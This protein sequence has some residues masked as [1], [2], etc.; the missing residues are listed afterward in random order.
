[1]EVSVALHPI[2]QLVVNNSIMPLHLYFIAAC[3]FASLFFLKNRGWVNKVTPLFLIVLF[4][5]EYY[6]YILKIKHR[7]NNYQYN[8][9]FPIEFSFY[10]LLLLSTFVKIKTKQKL[11]FLVYLYW[12][13]TIVNYCFFQN[14]SQ[15]SGSTY[16]AS[17]ILLLL[18]TFYKM[19]ELLYAAVINNPFYDP[20][21][22]LIIGL[23]TVHVL[24]IF[25][26]SATDYLYTNHLTVYR[27][28][29]KLNLYLTYFQYSCML[30]YF[31]TKWN[32][33]R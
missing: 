31:F 14:L 27:A 33:Q 29:Q 7:G 3:F 30:I 23:I 21:F 15:F 24:G 2:L 12:T 13:F 26:F 28:L 32:F 9:W 22:W 17:V 1:M 11:Y 4:I 25:Q 19:R 5:V 20:L 18:I 10:S 6:C 8:F 16:M